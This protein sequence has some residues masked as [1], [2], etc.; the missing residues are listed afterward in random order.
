VFCSVKRNL[1]IV[2]DFNFLHKLEV[3]DELNV[4]EDEG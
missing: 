4:D 1:S 3:D 2:C